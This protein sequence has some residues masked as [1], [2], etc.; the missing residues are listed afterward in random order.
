MRGIRF[1]TAVVEKESHKQLFANA[2]AMQQI[3]EKV[4][5][6][7]LKLRESDLELFNDGLEYLRRDMEGSDVDTRR[8]CVWFCFR[9]SLLS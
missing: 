1:L 7:Q 8:R 4:I 2:T 9:P 6:P 3:C 5:I